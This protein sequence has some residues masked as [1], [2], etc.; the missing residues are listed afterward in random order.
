MDPNLKLSSELNEH[1]NKYFIVRNLRSGKYSQSF[2][3]LLSS[4]VLILPNQEGSYRLFKAHAQLIQLLAALEK[5]TTTV[6]LDR[7]PPDVTIKS[8]DMPFWGSYLKNSKKTNICFKGSDERYECDS[9]EYSLYLGVEKGQQ[10][11]A[12]KIKKTIKEKEVELFSEAVKKTESGSIPAQQK[13][14]QSLEEL[15]VGFDSCGQKLQQTEAKKKEVKLSVKNLV[16]GIGTID[17]Q[18]DRIIIIWKEVLHFC[19]GSPFLKALT[20]RKIRPILLL[21]NEKFQKK[22]DEELVWTEILKNEEFRKSEAMRQQLQAK[23]SEVLAQKT[24]EKPTIVNENTFVML[25]QQK[26]GIVVSAQIAL[27]FVGVFLKDY[28][29]LLGL[30][31]EREKR[32]NTHLRESTFGASSMKDMTK[33]LLKEAREVYKCFIL[34]MNNML[35]FS[36]Y[37]VDMPYRPGFILSLKPDTVELTVVCQLKAQ[38]AVQDASPRSRP[39]IT[40]KVQEDYLEGSAEYLLSEMNRRKQE[41]FFIPAAKHLHFDYHDEQELILLLASANDKRV[42]SWLTRQTPNPASQQ[43]TLEGKEIKYW[44]IPKVMSKDGYYVETEAK[45]GITSKDGFAIVLKDTAKDEDE[46]KENDE[47]KQDTSTK[48]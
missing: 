17:S 40:I 34:L 14:K 29:K 4:S 21:P 25:A 30:E 36:G 44:C 20:E 38:I 47:E 16:E 9:A 7:L 2:Q 28:E 12:L 42:S 43:V 45:L 13:S 46:S 8:P 27:Y 10:R 22:I 39:N 11:G 37:R 41:R 24:R 3:Q 32:H 19:W 6:F 18:T 1:L 33:E 23:F 5:K 15:L 48:T 31:L 26:E 35:L